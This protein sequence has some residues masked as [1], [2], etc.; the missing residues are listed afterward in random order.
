MLFN[1]RCNARW[2]MATVKLGRLNGLLGIAIEAVVVA[3]DATGPAGG[4]ADGVELPADPS[5][6]K[7]SADNALINSAVVLEP[8]PGDR[9]PNSSRSPSAG[10]CIPGVRRRGVLAPGNV[11]LIS[12]CWPLALNLEGHVD[13]SRD[14]APVAMTTPELRNASR[15]LL[16]PGLLEPC[17]L[18]PWPR[19]PLD[20]KFRSDVLPQGL[21][22]PSNDATCSSLR[23]SLRLSLGGIE[24][25][26][27]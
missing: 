3:S 5:P 6:P 8:L 24:I 23:D 12:C 15:P 11:L 25:G 4:V 9:G 18:L 10:P 26:V 16:L 19:S 20:A 21:A 2:G 7:T 17:F 22:T 13:F 14:E 27:T 1:W